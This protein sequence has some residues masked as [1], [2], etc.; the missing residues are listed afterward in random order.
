MERS[1]KEL[2]WHK[3]RGDLATYI[4]ETASNNLLMCC[5]CGR[6][7]PSEFFDLEHIISQQAVK[8]DPESVRA[9]PETPANT[10]AGNLLLCR[11]PLLYRGSKLYDNGCNSWKGRF[12]DKPITKIFSGQVSEGGGITNALIV[13][14]LVLGYLAMVA[15]FGYVVALM[16]SGRLM[17][18]QFFRP[19]SFHKDLDARYQLLLGGVPFTASDAGVWRSP[20]SFK[21]EDR[22]CLVT[23]RNFVV[24]LPVSQ[25]P[26]APLAR[27][28]RIVPTRY[29]F[30]P[31]FGSSF[32]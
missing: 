31:D 16:P 12:Y 2:L 30:R 5:A 27:H 19:G 17:R 4:P 8:R 23:V 14:G 18:E 24:R 26:S 21:F 22:S 13:G 3:M 6:F 20:F 15:Q 29:K 11:K 28:L 10:R 32:G 9:D 1:I 7:L 25:D